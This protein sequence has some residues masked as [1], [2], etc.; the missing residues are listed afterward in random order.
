MARPV[1]NCARLVRR[2]AAALGAAALSLACGDFAGSS[3][4]SQ[5]NG[6]GF[7][8][9]SAPAGGI[10]AFSTTVYPIVREHC[11]SCHEGNGPGSP[12]FASADVP[13]SYQ[14]MTGQGKV[15][16]GAPASSRIVVKLVSLAHNCWSSCAADGAALTAAI[17]AWAEAV[18]YGDGGVSVDG[19]LASGT[20]RF[21][22]GVV[23][24]SGERY[25]GNL[26]ALYEFKEGSGT[27]AHDTSGNLPALDLTLRD[28]VDWMTSWGVA[29]EAGS[30]VASTALS[31]R[32]Y[33]RVA[34]PERGTQQYTIE[35]WITPDNIAQG[36]DTVAR[37]V[38]Y[39]S[40]PGSSNMALGQAE[41]NYNAR[42]RTILGDSSGNGTPA[43]QTADADRDAQ[44]RLQ[45]VVLTYD[46]FRGRRLFVDGR[47]TGDVDPLAAA[48]LWNWDPNHRLAVGAEPNREGPWQGQVRL[49]AIY[50]QALTQAQIQQNYEAGVGE[51]L[52]LRFD[53]AQW[54][55]AGSAIEFIV[56][57]FDGFSY[58]FCQPTLRVPN[59]NGSRIANLQ[60]AVNGELAPNGQGFATVDTTSTGSK[61]ELSRQCA[62]IPKG[63]S[64]PGGDQFTLVFEHLG[65]Y[66]NVVVSDPVPPA[67]IPL[68][69]DARPGNGI[70]NFARVNASFAKLS[71]QSR[72]VAQATFDEITEQLPPGYDVRSF[73]SSQQVAI[74]KI[75]LEY[76][77]ALIDGPGR[78]TF[79]PG[80]DF[81]ASP[82]T[83]FGTAASRDLIF[84][85]LYDRM[86][87][88]GLVFQPTRG[89]VR[90]A[91]DAMTDQLVAPCATP[92]VC[93]S[94][95][96]T[97]IAKSACTAVLGSAA[98][99]L[100]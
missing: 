44:D 41:Y 94:Q 3:S 11:A 76:C 88:D 24:T 95:R 46:Q 19:Q 37:I 97:A 7:L 8:D 35:A 14:A 38:T 55:G 18:D 67:P 79:F 78:A 22:D 13:A 80:F 61:Q 4:G 98:V 100:H 21:T 40:S 43:L 63:A 59:P 83:A 84:D 32:I 30:L 96:T 93:N 85:P 28:D 56:T 58:L 42:T 87:G 72:S 69:P 29:L 74:A 70:R 71:G 36:A 17:E 33:D 60:I 6:N 90:A 1:K 20:Q 49:L 27:I 2:V 53:V 26:L 89:E 73:V 86:V 25:R 23:D 81:N 65:G 99:T 16:L 39:S 31:R 47:W 91:L 5:N 51:R 10:S 9:L 68:D 64:G 34:D 54:M 82:G 52:L 77:S 50:Q 75:S 12:H 66:Q 48:R 57:D 62:V 45:H 92:G 15:N